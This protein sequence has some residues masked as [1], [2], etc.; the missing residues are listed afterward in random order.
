[1]TNQ[2]QVLI[3]TNSDV[4][5]N[6]L[7]QLEQLFQTNQFQTWIVQREKPLPFESEQLAHV[8]VNA[9][10]GLD[11]IFL[12]SEINRVLKKDG[13]LSFAHMTANVRVSTFKNLF[14]SHYGCF[15]PR[16]FSIHSFTQKKSS[17][18]NTQTFSP[19]KHVNNTITI[20]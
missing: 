13:T 4:A 10:S 1:M 14:F 2:P 19:S 7:P 18:A 3:I 5:I 12:L 8:Y 15:F 6:T 16:F 9:H 20:Q 11:S 17:K